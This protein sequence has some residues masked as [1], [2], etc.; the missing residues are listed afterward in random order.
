MSDFPDLPR[1]KNSKTKEERFAEDFVI[2]TL[3]NKFFMLAKDERYPKTKEVTDELDF[4]VNTIRELQKE[5]M[6]NSI[7]Q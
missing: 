3:Q 1:V 4:I 7:Q 2:K 5:N 6:E